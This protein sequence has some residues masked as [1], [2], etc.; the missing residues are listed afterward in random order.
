MDTQLRPCP[1]LEYFFEGARTTRQGDEGVCKPRHDLLPFMHCVYHTQ[2]AQ[3]LVRDLAVEESARHHSRH[4]STGRDN[5]VSQH[6]HQS[7][8][9]ASV[10]ETK[11]R[12]H[13]GTCHGSGCLF[14]SRA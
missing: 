2:L 6:A 9:A 1:L 13:E 10:D 4:M 8:S 11:I 14:I 7:N 5:C 3:P 12:A